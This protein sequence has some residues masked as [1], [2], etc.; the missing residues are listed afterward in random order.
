MQENS[1]GFWAAGSRL[2]CA[3]LGLRARGG[4]PAFWLRGDWNGFQDFELKLRSGVGVV[5]EGPD[6]G[7]RGAER[8][9]SPWSFAAAA[10]SS[11]TCSPPSVSGGRS[12]NP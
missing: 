5:L 7:V 8:T 4:G 11:A 1:F 10:Y 2:L 6:L 9:S 12:R 3:G